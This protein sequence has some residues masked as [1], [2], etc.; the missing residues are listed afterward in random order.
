MEYRQY[1]REINKRE[2]NNKLHYCI[3]IIINL[4]SIQFNKEEKKSISLEY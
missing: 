4:V 1:L 2:I 3:S